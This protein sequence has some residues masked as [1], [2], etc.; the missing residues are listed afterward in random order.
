MT[1]APSYLAAFAFWVGGALGRAILAL[2]TILGILALLALAALTAPLWLAW[3]AWEWR[4]TS[5]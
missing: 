4:K 5:R 3:I 2:P 1:R